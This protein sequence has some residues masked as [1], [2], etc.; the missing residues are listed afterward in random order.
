MSIPRT[1][2]NNNP[3]ILDKVEDREGNFY[4]ALTRKNA[5]FIIETQ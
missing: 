5:D 4:A 3:Y 1:L 2:S